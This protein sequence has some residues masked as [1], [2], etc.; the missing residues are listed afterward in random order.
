MAGK[1]KGDGGRKWRVEGMEWD[2]GLWQ[3]ESRQLPPP[4]EFT[5]DLAFYPVYTYTSGASVI[6]PR[7]GWHHWVHHIDPHYTT[8]CFCYYCYHYPP[9][10]PS[11]LLLFA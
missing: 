2:E 6:C 8:N 11:L 5:R 10:H 9:P 3:R 7:G 4:A 1:G